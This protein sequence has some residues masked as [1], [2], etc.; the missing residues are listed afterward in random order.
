M[1]N[2]DGEWRDGRTDPDIYFWKKWRQNGF[3]LCMANDI[4]I[5]HMQRVVTMSSA[6]THQDYNLEP[7]SFYQVCESTGA[8]RE[9]V[10]A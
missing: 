1:P 4:N 7:E 8:Q 3:N 9:M 10:E 5:G 2:S 6:R